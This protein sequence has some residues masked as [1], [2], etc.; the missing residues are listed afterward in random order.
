MI[1]EILENQEKQE[2]I[3]IND[4]LCPECESELFREGRCTTCLECG[5]SE[6]SL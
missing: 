2:E 4:K 3:K 1:Q 5:W 6:C